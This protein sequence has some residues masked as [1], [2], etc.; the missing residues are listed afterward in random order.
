VRR[1]VRNAKPLAIVVPV[2]VRLVV[3]AAVG[4]SVGS[5]TWRRGRGGSGHS[6]SKKPQRHPPAPVAVCRQPQRQ[7]A[8]GAERWWSRCEG[9]AAR[10]LLARRS[11]I[12]RR[13]LCEGDGRL[14]RVRLGG[15]TLRRRERAARVG[16]EAR[17]RFVSVPL[18]SDLVQRWFDF[19]NR[20]RPHPSAPRWRSLHR[21]S[22]A[23]AS[24]EA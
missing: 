15:A 22:Q 10:V 5:T 8:L 7:S 23:D 9:D 2:P 19:G 3:L 21:R 12:D 18:P 1:S 17:R 24:D 13:P 6:G 20:W 16:G 11:G 14:K 4:G